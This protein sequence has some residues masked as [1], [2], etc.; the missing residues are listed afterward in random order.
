MKEILLGTGFGC[1]T[2]IERGPDGFLYVISLN[3]RTIYRI[4]PIEAKGLDDSNISESD[5]SNGGG[6]LIATAAYGSEL[7][8]QVQQ[9][10]E[11]RDNKLFQ[12]E[13][14]SNFI[15]GF[16]DIYYTFSPTIA[17][18]ERENVYFKEFVKFAITPMISSLSILSQVDMDSENEVLGFGISLILLNVGMYIGVPVAIV[19]GIRKQF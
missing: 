16:N 13:I 14:G 11:I 5:S 1:I 10:R 12:T 6:C 7:S 18:Y 8:L 15:S 19:V 2:D 9:L 17:D 3:E 4:L